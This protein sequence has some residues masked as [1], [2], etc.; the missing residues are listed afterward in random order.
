[1]RVLH[2]APQDG[3]GGRQ[4]LGVGSGG[5]PGPGVRGQGPGEGLGPTGW[6]WRWAGAGR[7]PGPHR[8]ALE[9]GRVRGRTWAPRNG[10]GGG[11][12]LGEGRGQG[13]A[14]APLDGPGGGQGPGEGLG[15][16]GRP[17]R[18][19]GSGGGPGPHG[20]ALEVGIGWQTG[21]GPLLQ[22]CVAL[23]ATAPLPLSPQVLCDFPH[24]AAAVPPDYLLD[25]L[26]LIRPRAFSIASSLRVREE[27]WPRWGGGQGDKGP[28]GGGPMGQGAYCPLPR[29]TPRGCR[30][31]WPWCS[32]RPASGS[33][34]V[35]S[36]PAG[37]RP[38]TL[39]KVTL[40]LWGGGW[41]LGLRASSSCLP[42]AIGPVRV[43]LW[44][45]S[46]GLTFPKTPD[47]PVIMVGPGTGVAPF[48]AAIQERVAQGETGEQSLGRGGGRLSSRGA[49]PGSG[50]APCPPTPRKCAVLR[51]PPAGPGLL[52][53]GRVGAAAG[54][55]LPDS[56]HGL[57]PGAGVCGRAGRGT[58]R[59]AQGADSECL[60]PA[61]PQEQKVYVQ[62]RLRALGPL[63]WELL[64]GRG[65][66]FYLAG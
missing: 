60:P 51:M 39:R 37:W 53:G 58:G 19:A 45:R 62:H 15:P 44:V 38:W 34:A 4:R 3:P 11:Q 6:P 54:E 9:M 2:P 12:G 23:P 25:L 14:W 30:S 28:G 20:T 27:G 64:D 55:R 66:H 21:L 22:P 18:W 43:P 48:R 56:G 46:G 1:M 7:E 52:L 61:A 63:V 47:V 35:A 5:G 24:T 31:W 36:A 10:P 8:T 65:A 33:P 50:P 26:P 59:D 41:A 42:H 17:W 29:P 49:G 32:T 13:R 57:L 16:T 40:A